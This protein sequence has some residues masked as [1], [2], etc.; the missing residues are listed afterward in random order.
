ML[1]VTSKCMH[2]GH[3]LST[4]ST[5]NLRA[6][7]LGMELQGSC[8]CG[9]V[10]FRCLSHA[11]VPFMR[12]YCSICRKSAGAGGYAINIMAEVGGVEGV[13]CAVL[14]CSSTLGERAFLMATLA[15]SEPTG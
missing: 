8:K 9:A 13:C 5:R 6:Q 14:C 1:H 3:L 2:F 12:C 4:H 11:P 10:R 7:A 15:L